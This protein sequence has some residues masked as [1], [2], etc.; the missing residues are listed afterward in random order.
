[1][2]KLSFWRYCIFIVGA[3]TEFDQVHYTYM[4][5][6][7]LDDINTWITDVQICIPKFASM[8]RCILNEKDIGCPYQRMF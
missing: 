6:M 2:S 5:Q 1:M 8:R 3:S 4:V 7:D